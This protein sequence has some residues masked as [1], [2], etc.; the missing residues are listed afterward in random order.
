MP[1][2][3]MTK[4]LA[5]SAMSVTMTKVAKAV[6]AFHGMPSAPN[7]TIA[8]PTTP[9]VSAGPTATANGQRSPVP[10]ATTAPGTIMKRT[11]ASTPKP[12]FTGLV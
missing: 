9:Y 4:S 5:A 6:H 2:R 10:H 8:R 7:G 11:A 1:R 3:R 12:K